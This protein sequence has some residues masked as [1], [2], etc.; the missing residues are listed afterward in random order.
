MTVLEVHDQE[1]QK[2]QRGID[3][4]EKV[5]RMDMGLEMSSHDE[6]QLSKLNDYQVFSRDFVPQALQSLNNNS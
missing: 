3:L 2:L 6:F 5:H 4:E 1:R